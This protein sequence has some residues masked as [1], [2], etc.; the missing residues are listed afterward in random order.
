MSSG[1]LTEDTIVLVL[2]QFRRSETG[3]RIRRSESVGQNLE[4]ESGGQNLEVV[5]LDRTPL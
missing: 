5:P 2:V 1:S 3:G 4:V